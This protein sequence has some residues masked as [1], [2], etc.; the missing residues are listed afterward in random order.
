MRYFVSRYTRCRVGFTA[1]KLTGRHIRDTGIEWFAFEPVD[2]H[3]AV[4]IE[5]ENVD[6]RIPATENRD[7]A[8]NPNL[9]NPIFQKL[10]SGR[11]RKQAGISPPAQKSPLQRK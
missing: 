6:V 2:D 7:R 4:L 1:A 11:E 9:S 10:D 3:G 8:F 5:L